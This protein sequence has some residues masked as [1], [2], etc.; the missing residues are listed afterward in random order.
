[1]GFADKIG[2]KIEERDRNR[3]QD[4]ENL[5]NY[6][7]GLDIAGLDYILFDIRNIIDSGLYKDLIKSVTTKNKYNMDVKAFEGYFKERALGMAYKTLKKRNILTTF[8]SKSII[9]IGDFLTLHTFME[10]VY[11]LNIGRRT[12]DDDL[13]NI[14]FSGLE[15]CIIFA[16]DHFD[17]VEL[18]DLPDVSSEY[19]QSLK[20]V[21]WADKELYKKL[22]T[23]MFEVMDFML[24]Y[25]TI[26]N[27]PHKYRATE[28]IFIQFLAACNAVNDGRLGIETEDTIVAYNTFFKLI[29]TDVTKYKAIP[30][31]VQGING[32]QGNASQDGYLVCDKCKS[33]YKLES[34]ESADDFEDI[35]ECGGHLVYKESI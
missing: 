25:P 31:L 9:F 7:D 21:Y 34:G 14:Y 24:D 4:M 3:Q 29:K 22:T 33:H 12:N 26:D 5:F 10:S 8:F 17:E 30:E 32:Y 19:F 11:Y 28:D 13:L 16:L 1:M 18:D 23:L 15:E 27:Y 2:E 35:C 20:N 6:L